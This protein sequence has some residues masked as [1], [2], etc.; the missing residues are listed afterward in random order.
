M[1]RSRDR[2][3]Q[4]ITVDKRT[5]RRSAAARRKLCKPTAPRL[6]IGQERVILVFIDLSTKIASQ[7]HR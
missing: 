6:T 3:S 7:T 4:K 2:A 5:K 1:T